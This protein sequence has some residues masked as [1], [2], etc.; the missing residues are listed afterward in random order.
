MCNLP[1]QVLLCYC[2]QSGIGCLK[3]VGAKWG[4]ELELIC[5]CHVS[6]AQ[7]PAPSQLNHAVSSV[8]DPSERYKA[9]WMLSAQAT[10]CPP[11]RDYGSLNEA[12]RRRIQNKRYRIR[13]RSTI[14]Q[15]EFHSLKGRGHGQSW[16]ANQRRLGNH[17][18]EQHVYREG[19]GGG[20]NHFKG[21]ITFQ[22]PA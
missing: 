7:H 1:L 20:K 10:Q 8:V 12:A 17:P 2:G 22:N 13:R 14:H 4:V 21:P 5:F 19:L 6:C 11:S 9:L 3:E 15:Q 18:R 16:H